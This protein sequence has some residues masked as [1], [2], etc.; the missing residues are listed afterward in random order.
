MKNRH[1]SHLLLTGEVAHLL[2]ISPDTVRLWAR[3]RR[4]S[5]RY[6]PRTTDH[7]HDVLS[8][9]LRTAVKW[10]HLRDNPARDVDLPALTNVRPKWALTIPPAT[11]LLDGLP[12]LARNMV[13]LAMLSGLRRGELFALRWRDFDEQ[14]QCLTV[15]ESVYEGAFQHAQDSRRGSTDS[16]V[17]RRRDADGGLES[18]REAYR[19][20]GVGVLDVVG[21]ADFAEQH[22]AALD[23]SGLCGVEPEA[24]DLADA[25]TNVLVLGAREGRPRQSHRATDG[26]REG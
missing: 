17:R 16:A 12:P 11:A 7:I 19:T 18:A 4:L 25:A 2:G 8:A 26:A 5:P 22:L 14:N 20:R 23:L 10:G 21:Q 6:A 15:R 1:E 24:G 9:V 13:G 3:L